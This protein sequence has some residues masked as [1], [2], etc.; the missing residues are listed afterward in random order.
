MI[1]KLFAYS[2]DNIDRIY[3]Q[4][5]T[6]I[7]SKGNDINFGDKEEE[8]FARE[9]MCTVQIYGKGLRNVLKG[10]TPKGFGWSGKKV[11]RLMES[12]VADAKNPTGFEYTYPEL[13][14]RMF[15]EQ[16]WEAKR[17][18][19]HNWYNQ[20]R[21]AAQYLKIDKEDDIMSNRNVGVLYQ[22][23]MHQMKDKPCFNWFQIR[24]TGKGK[25]S[26]RL[27]FRSHDYGD[28]IW[29]NLS[30]VGHGFNELVFKPCGV[31]LEEII[32]VSASAHV[33]DNQSDLVENLTGIKWNKEEIPKGVA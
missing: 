26:L 4:I 6:D 10:K 24:Y 11:K 20:T 30:S 2:D 8:K 12:F 22:P 9:I 18:G 27:L 19:R 32:V 5:A 17:T 1:T 13:L 28:A 29:A 3:K 14:S 31:E 16:I 23:G 7:I 15:G 25:G 33:Y 21:L